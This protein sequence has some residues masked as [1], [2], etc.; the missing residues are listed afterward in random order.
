[1]YQC[2]MLKQLNIYKD[3]KTYS[4]RR[5]QCAFVAVP[6]LQRALNALKSINK[7]K[8]IG[9]SLYNLENCYY[10]MKEYD[11]DGTKKIKATFSLTRYLH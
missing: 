2:T 9:A 6:H 1:M 5:I 7:Q 10:S 3:Q 8:L 4:V 11:K